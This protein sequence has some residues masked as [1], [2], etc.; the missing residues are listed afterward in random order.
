LT[1]LARFKLMSSDDLRLIK[2]KRPQPL[3]NAP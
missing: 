2:L 3:V 1:I